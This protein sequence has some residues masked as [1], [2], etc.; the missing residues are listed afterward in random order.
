M[1]STSARKVARSRGGQPVRIP[2]PPPPLQTPPHP[3]KFSNASFSNLRF[4]GKVLAPKAPKFFFW[5]P[6]GVFFFT[7]CVYT[8]N[9]QTFVEKSKMGEK[10]IKKFDP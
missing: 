3:P 1:Q 8:Q 2:D 7:L 6:E 4:L 5:P 9:T 10:Y